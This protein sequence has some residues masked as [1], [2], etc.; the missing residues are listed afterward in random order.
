M[1]Q[2][3]GLSTIFRCQNNF[4]LKVNLSYIDQSTMMNGESTMDSLQDEPP[5]ATALEA[6]ILT[7]AQD[8]D[9]LMVKNGWMEEP[10]QAEDRYQLISPTQM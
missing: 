6:D 3:K 1:N 8:G 9:K 7:Y 10:P 2:D 4:T 5:S